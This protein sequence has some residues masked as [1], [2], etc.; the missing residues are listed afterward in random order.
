MSG[1]SRKKRKAP[2]TS[3]SKQSLSAQR[4]R[5]H[6]KRGD[7][8]FLKKRYGGAVV[9]SGRSRKFEKMYGVSEIDKN[10]QMQRV[11]RSRGYDNIM[12]LADMSKTELDKEIQQLSSLQATMEA[13][14]LDT[15]GRRGGQGLIDNWTQ[16]GLDLAG[17]GSDRNYR[18]QR[19]G[20]FGVVAVSRRGHR[21]SGKTH[22]YD[23]SGWDEVI[24]TAIT[25]ERNVGRRNALRDVRV[26]DSKYRRLQRVHEL[27]A[28]TSSLGR[29]HTGGV[30]SSYDG[31]PGTHSAHSTSTDYK[32]RG[33]GSN[34]MG[35]RLRT[36]QMQ[37]EEG[38]LM[39]KIRNPMMAELQTARL[40][41]GYA[42]SSM[43]M[44][45]PYTAHTNLSL[46]DSATDRS[47]KKA[48]VWFTREREIKPMRRSLRNFAS[49]RKHRSTRF[50]SPSP[51]RDYR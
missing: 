14:I 23:A 13:Q 11:A 6:L 43:V 51:P 30:A 3:H 29:L 24:Q 35:H 49:F 42:V 48:A 9:A 28:V 5:E 27:M 41:A 50:A 46:R 10:R 40:R 33:V 12:R 7:Y 26:S 25:R 39:K 38:K 34:P 17:S 45:S 47:A 1:Y 8:I 2:S 32:T 19:T 36:E 20:R 31:Y 44:N 15:W 16:K 18:S 21:R 22:Y 37:L 4:A